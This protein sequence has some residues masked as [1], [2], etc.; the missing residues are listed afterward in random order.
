MKHFF[1]I[2]AIFVSL[3]AG[4]R[5]ETC[6]QHISPEGCEAVRGTSLPVFEDFCGS[7]L[8]PLHCD[9]GI[10]V[11]VF[12][13]NTL[14][15]DHGSDSFRHSFSEEGSAYRVCKAGKTF[16]LKHYRNFISEYAQNPSGARRKDRYLHYLRQLLV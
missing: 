11:C 7:G 12:T 8:S 15:S 1:L 4:D 6:R 13:V 16:D 14:T 3:L 10:S 9:F 5:R 2:F